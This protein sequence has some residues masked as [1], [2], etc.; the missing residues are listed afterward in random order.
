MAIPLRRHLKDR[1]PTSRISSRHPDGPGQ[2]RRLRS[3]N[4]K[5]DSLGRPDVDRSHAPRN[6]RSLYRGKSSQKLDGNRSEPKHALWQRS[7]T[8]EKLSIPGPFQESDRSTT[9]RDA[10]KTDV[11]TTRPQRFTEI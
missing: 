3:P 5:R 10:R 1:V 8:E 4:T 7:P 11:P 2:R 9:H 6:Q